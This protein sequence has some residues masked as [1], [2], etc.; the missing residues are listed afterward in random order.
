MNMKYTLTV[1]AF[2]AITAFTTIARDKAFFVSQPT[3]SPDGQTIVFVYENDLWQVPASGGTAYRLT[4]LDGIVSAPRFSPDGEWIAFT[5]TRDRNANVY[6]MPAGGGEIQQLTW[7]Q[8]SDQVNSWSWDS[9]SIY[10]HSTRENMSSVFSVSL[11]GGTPKRLFE[12]Y[13]NIEHQLSEHPQT[14]AYIFTESWESLMFPQ[15][16]RYKGEHRPDI[17]SYNAETDEFINLTNYEGQDL[18]PSIDRNGNIFFASDEFNGEYNLYTFRDGVKTQLTSFPRSIRTPQVSADGSIVAFEKD[19]QLY[20]YEVATGEVLTPEV[21]LFQA[22]NLAVDQS[23]Q[24]KG[25]ITWF[26]VSPDE[27]KLAFVSR[28]ELFVSDMEGKFVRQMPVN[29]DE[30]VIEVKWLADNKTLLYTRTHNGWANLFTIAADGKGGEKQVENTAQTSRALAISQDRE[31]AVY[32]SGRNEVKLVDLESFA[33]Q[34]LVTDEL[35]GFQNSNPTF[36]P[37]GEYVLFTAFRK[38]EQDVMIHHIASGETFNLTQSGVTQRQPCWSPCGRYIYFSS[39]RV[40]PNYPTGNTE[41]S[42]YRI[43]LHKF[44]DPFRQGAFEKLF[45]EKDENDTLPA[46]VSVEI[47]RDRME[48]RWEQIRVRGGAQWSPQVYKAKEGQVMFFISNHD[49]GEMALWKTEM[50]PFEENKTER[51]QG[52]NPGMSPLIVNLKDNYWVLAGGHIQ[53]LDVKGNKMEPVDFDYTFSRNLAKEFTQVFYETWTT[54][55]ENFYD[56]DFHGINWKATLDHYEQFLPHMRSRDN[57]RTLLNDML[58]ELNASHMGFSGSGKEEEPFFKGETAET[59]LVF[60]EVNPW[61]VKRIITG[62]HLDL[63]DKPILP[64]DVLLAVNG[65]RVENSGNR[66]RY[67]YFASRP[68]ELELTFRRGNSEVKVLTRSHTPGQISNLLYDEWIRDNRQYV[69]DK[70]ENRIAYVHMKNMSEGALEQFLI[71]M[72]TYAERKDAL[73]F[74]IR[75]NRGGNVHNDVLQFLSQRPYLAWKYRG[76]EMAPQPNFAPAA[77]PMVLTI[78]ERSLSD[79][80]MT[81]EG[82]RQLELG[83]IIGVETYRWIIFTSGK[84]FVDGSFCRL[85]SWGCYTLDGENLEF[86]GVAPDIVVPETFHDRLHNRKPQLDSAIDEL[87]KQL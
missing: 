34:V 9:Q 23:F 82:F 29:A 35:W 25:N 83:K 21:R 50:K 51:I 18:W 26:D 37:N 42:I 16:K 24:V 84:S 7:H 67:F 12:H 6:V 40:N 19:Y 5:S 43:A 33:T 15:R 66:N 61:T 71:D 65:V 2:L 68:E 30:R 28:G 79:A 22:P 20:V 44:A 77:K 41:N 81:A 76:G 80:E 56:D 1:I 57:L 46:A 70:S 78:N 72:T 86:T 11:E 73:L 63:T 14:G 17:L 48:E 58:G 10:F 47:D 36:S 49:K 3:A 55:E 53:K 75:F 69:R 85:P 13:F 59:G 45:E 32:L 74:D 4:S 60:E 52:A 27:K 31:K 87:L 54:L 38:F 39:D 62:S 64:G 8:G